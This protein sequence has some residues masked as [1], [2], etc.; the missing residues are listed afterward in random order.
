ML[1]CSCNRSSASRNPTQ[2]STAP[3][4]IRGVDSQ[5]R[6]RRL[7]A[8]YGFGVEAQEWMPSVAGS[9]VPPRVLRVEK[10]IRMRV[11]YTCHLCE[12]SF[13]VE[14]NCKMCNHRRCDE[15]PRNPPK[16]NKQKDDG[17]KEN[18][19]K[20]DSD[21][22]NENVWGSRKRGNQ[23]SLRTV[24]QRTGGTSTAVSEGPEPVVQQLQYYCH[25]C[26]GEIDHMAQLCS[27]C[28]HL[29][30]SQCPRALINWSLT[31]AARE[32]LKTER[33]YREPRQRIRWICDHC[34]N[35]FMEGSRVCAECLHKRCSECLR[36]PYD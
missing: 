24:Q 12:T 17:N 23:E 16:R 10:P 32:P 6:S 25:H 15:C 36:I 2:I 22:D 27:S 33:V 7:F 35:T 1:Q 20:A 8:K 34:Q 30:C 13:G 31:Q 5:E 9:T 4:Y 3:V 26:S 21:P 29:R 28:G 19:A 18:I 11:R 14:K